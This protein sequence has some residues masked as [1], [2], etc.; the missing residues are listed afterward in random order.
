MKALEHFGHKTE[1]WEAGLALVGLSAPES[2]LSDVGRLVGE[3]FV[4]TACVAFTFQLPHLIGRSDGA[5]EK[6]KVKANVHTTHILVC[7]PVGVVEVGMFL[8][9]LGASR[10]PEPFCW[11]LN[12]LVVVRELKA[13]LH[14]DQQLFYKHASFS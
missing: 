2:D 13:I 6:I 7:I 10:C 5:L 11:I 9:F 14:L 1:L 4:E 12:I 8:D 3:L